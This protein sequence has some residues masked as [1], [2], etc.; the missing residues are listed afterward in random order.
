MSEPQPPSTEEGPE[1]DRTERIYRTIEDPELSDRNVMRLLRTHLSWKDWFYA[2]FLRYVYWLAS[3]TLDVFIV[4]ELARVFEV[5]DSVGAFL[6]LVTLAIL[7][8]VESIPYR[9]L[10]PEGPL[11]RRRAP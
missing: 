2:D 11:T 9:M 4:L 10:W 7:V 3:S 1:E 5:R 8:I 6:L